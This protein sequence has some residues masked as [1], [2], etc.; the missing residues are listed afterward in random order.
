MMNPDERAAI[1]VP[2]F[3]S[4]RQGK[5]PIT[6]LYVGPNPIEMLDKSIQEGINAIEA[7]WSVPIEAVAISHQWFAVNYL[8]AMIVFKERKSD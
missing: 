2:R 1:G 7:E 6:N 3:F 5:D 4:A 8:S